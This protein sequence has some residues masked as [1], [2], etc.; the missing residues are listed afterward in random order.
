MPP[1]IQALSAVLGRTMVEAPGLE[2]LTGPE[3]TGPGFRSDT[4]FGSYQAPDPEP[5][6]LETALG[7]YF[8][9]HPQRPPG[10]IMRDNAGAWPTP[11]VKQQTEAA[12]I[13]IAQAIIDHLNQTEKPTQ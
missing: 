11:W 13:L 2:F 7:A 6:T 4:R 1:S 8:T 5:D 3:P 10:D 9:E 12:L